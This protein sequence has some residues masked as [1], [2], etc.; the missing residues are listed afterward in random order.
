MEALTL[1]CTVSGFAITGAWYLGT[2]FS[3]I[4]SRLNYLEKTTDE[5]KVDVK[6]LIKT[7][8]WNNSS[9]L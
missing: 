1:F 4:K 8:T 9:S 3:R 7:K 5:L 2:T 6:E